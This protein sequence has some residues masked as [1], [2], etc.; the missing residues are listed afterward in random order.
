[1]LDRNSVLSVYGD[2]QIATSTDFY[3]GSDS[4]ALRVVFRFG[5]KIADTAR[6]VESRDRRTRQLVLAR[7]GSSSFCPWRAGGVG[8]ALCDSFDEARPHHPR[9]FVVAS[10]SPFT[11]SLPAGQSVCPGRRRCHTADVAVG[12]CS[13]RHL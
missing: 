7:R 9:R 12:L 10:E 4:I 8:R 1:M 3:F 6:V 13:R 2:V 5:Q 11:Q